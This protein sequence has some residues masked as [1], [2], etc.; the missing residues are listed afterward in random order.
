M[1]LQDITMWN[2]KFAPMLEYKESYMLFIRQWM[3]FGIDAII[4]SMDQNGSCNKFVA[5]TGESASPVEERIISDLSIGRNF[6]EE[7][8]R[9]VLEADFLN[10]PGTTECVSTANCIDIYALKLP[11]GLEKIVS[12]PGGESKDQRQLRISDLLV[13]HTLDQVYKNLC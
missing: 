4:Y 5:V 6:Y 12:V 10:L 13:G 2:A 8:I 3:P 9:K 11:D 7:L 1:K